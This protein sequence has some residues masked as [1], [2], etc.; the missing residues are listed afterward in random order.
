MRWAVA[1]H[2]L[3][4]WHFFGFSTWCSPSH[5]PLLKREE[6]LLVPVGGI[7]TPAAHRLGPA[8]LTAPAMQRRAST[9]SLGVLQTLHRKQHTW[10]SVTHQV[11]LDYSAAQSQAKLGGCAGDTSPGRCK[12]QASSTTGM[13]LPYTAWQD[14][15]QFTNK[16]YKM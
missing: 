16:C 6:C 2:T 12:H 3:L 5:S 4:L 15:F 1:D 14:S 11:T 10:G 8:H 7:W 13:V 9:E